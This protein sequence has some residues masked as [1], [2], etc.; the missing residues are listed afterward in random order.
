MLKV[1]PSSLAALQAQRQRG[2]ADSSAAGRWRPQLPP[3]RLRHPPPRRRRQVI[4][5]TRSI[6]FTPA[7]C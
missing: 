2:A 6:S 4:A 7:R 3:G 5:G 1:K